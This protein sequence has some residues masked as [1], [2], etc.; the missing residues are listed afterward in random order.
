MALTT[1]ATSGPADSIVVA[2]A[3][4]AMLGR[5]VAKTFSGPRLPELFSA[6]LRAAIRS[7]DLFVLNLECCI[8]SRGERWE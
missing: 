6:D 5:G 4:D 1:P 8:S 2:L 7:A 3:G